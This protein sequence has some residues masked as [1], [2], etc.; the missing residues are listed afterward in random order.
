MDT[1]TPK[2][3]GPKTLIV[4]ETMKRTQVTIDN[5][6][7]RKLMVIGGTVSGGIRMAADVAFDA[8]QNAEKRKPPQS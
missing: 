7:R 4:G 2:K 3:R 8:Y 1:K 6:T 5:M